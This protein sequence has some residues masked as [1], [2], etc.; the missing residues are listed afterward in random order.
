MTTL[1]IIRA[2]TVSIIATFGLAASAL[3]GPG[4]MLMML[5]GQMVTVTPLEKDVTYDNGTKV[6]KDGTVMMNG[7]K[8][9]LKEGQ[10]ISPAGVMMKPSASQAHGG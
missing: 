2:C 4:P 10:A 5:H 6:T 8:M 7:K 3:A 1:P 9:H